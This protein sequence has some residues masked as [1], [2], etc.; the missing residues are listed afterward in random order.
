MVGHSEIPDLTDGLPS[1]LSPA[2]IQ[3]LLREEL[4]FDGLVGTDALNMRAVSDRWNIEEA[5][6][7]ALGA[8]ADLMILGTLADVGPSFASIDEAVYDG[9][10]PVD[11]LN[12]AAVNVLRAKGI[13]SCTLVGR[14]RG[15]M[16]T[17][18]D[19]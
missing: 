13:N 7:M 18:Y 15:V 19:W 5:V 2:A 12:D 9:R 4:G 3:G 17:S 6:I 1:S 8:G 10:L 11:R 14:V 16:N